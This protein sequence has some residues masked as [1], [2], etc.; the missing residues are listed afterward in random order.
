[1]RAGTGG[2]PQLRGSEVV[3][4][5]AVPRQASCHFPCNNCGGSGLGCGK[6]LP[7]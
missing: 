7:P 3:E 6:A 4:R 2:S 5:A 1:M